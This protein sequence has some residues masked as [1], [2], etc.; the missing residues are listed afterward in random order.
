MIS[1]G[2]VV[3]PAP[4]LTHGDGRV[5]LPVLPYAS[6]IHG[7][8][9]GK[10]PGKASPTAALTQDVE[11]GVE[12]VPHIQDED[13]RVLG[14]RMSLS[15]QIGLSQVSFYSCSSQRCCVLSILQLGRAFLLPDRL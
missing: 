7:W 6:S 11:N 8:P 9:R 2:E 12:D 1:D 3:A 10:S 15:N 4:L 13:D 14:P 5:S